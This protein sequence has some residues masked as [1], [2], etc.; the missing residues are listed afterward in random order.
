VR[1]NSRKVGR[2]FGADGADGTDG[3]SGG[4]KISRSVLLVI[5]SAIIFSTLFCHGLEAT[6]FVLVQL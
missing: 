6:V 4:L 3:A 5:G 1:W 2:V